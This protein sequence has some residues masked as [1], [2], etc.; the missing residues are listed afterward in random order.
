MK[1]IWLKEWVE[2]PY[3]KIE[4]SICYDPQSLLSVHSDITDKI[5]AE[6]IF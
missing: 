2:S 3:I 4:T 6:L 1:V 5:I